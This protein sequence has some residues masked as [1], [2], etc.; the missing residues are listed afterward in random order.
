MIL[1]VGLS[2]SHTFPLKVW[3]ACA[4]AFPPTSLSHSAQSSLSPFYCHN[5][6]GQQ[7]LFLSTGNSQR[8]IGKKPTAGSANA[9][10]GAAPAELML[11]DYSMDENSNIRSPQRR[12]LLRTLTGVASTVVVGVSVPSQVLAGEVGARITKAVTTS[13][14]GISVRTS[15][16][17]GAQLADKID[18]KWEKF[19]DN[20]GL[21]SERT[22]RKEKEKV[23]PDPLPLNI[24]AAKK[25]LEASDETF[26]KLMP[27]LSRQNLN[28]RIE[29]TAKSTKA[30]FERSG[31]LFP[32]G[33]GAN[34]ATATELL[35][36]QTAPQF[37][38]IVYAHF[39]TYSELILENGSSIDFASF[40]TEY[41][42]NVGRRLIESLQLV[43][44]ESKPFSTQQQQEP[45]TVLKSQ[46]LAA[47][48]QTDVLG[49][50]LRELGLV[51]NIDRNSVESTDDLQDF[52]DDALAD[53]VIT[54]SIDG[55]VT[56]Q[57][58]L[59]LQEQGYRLYP[60]FNRF[61]VT[62]FFREAIQ[63]KQR[64]DQAKGGSLQSSSNGNSNKYDNIHKVSVIDYYFDT[65]YNSDPDKF[66]VKQVMLN[67]SIE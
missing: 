7:R 49:R 52:V 22:K 12:S 37:N 57:S 14:L 64:E 40:R 1:L 9:I 63:T 44:D 23:I 36:F 24:G 30:S 58:Q 34:V 39:K 29:K 32:V 60:N 26:L 62:E 66:E 28:S 67:I 33:E 19:S 38:F 18:G 11:R 51:S 42:Q 3:T 6:R 48:K 50:K 20:Y 5:H 41:E 16:V 53:L 43:E 25:I 8:N 10:E 21:G 55:D 54:V 2:L 35:L 17:K 27:S 56:L 4:F 31:V 61:V 15:V 47:L 13:D 46:I 45:S 59:L 65:N